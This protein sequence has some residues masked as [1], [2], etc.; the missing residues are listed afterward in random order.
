MWGAG[1]SWNSDEVATKV[2]E[3]HINHSLCI[4]V[5]ASG[6]WHYLLLM[7]LKRQLELTQKDAHFSILL[8]TQEKHMCT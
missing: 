1:G 2:H 5:T 3:T 8:H 7:V 4:S 6:M